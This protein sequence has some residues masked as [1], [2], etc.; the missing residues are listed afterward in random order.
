MQTD[1]NCAI[2]SVSTRAHTDPV[3][4][5]TPEPRRLG[6]RKLLWWTFW[7]VFLTTPVL[8][9]FSASLLDNHIPR[10]WTL[11]STLSSILAGAGTSGFILS[12]L[13]TKDGNII[14]FIGLGVAFGTLLTAAYF[15][16]AWILVSIDIVSVN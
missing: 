14:D 1:L 7:F 12:R 11:T 2:D 13:I 4:S 8:A 15:V 6:R 9:C 16:I 10:D 5:T 3:D